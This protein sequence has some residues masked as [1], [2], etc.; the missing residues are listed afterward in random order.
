MKRGFRRAGASRRR[1]A[2]SL[3]PVFT[4]V[5]LAIAAPAT[6]AANPASPNKKPP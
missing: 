6:I 4:M 3:L 5:A 1:F 2:H